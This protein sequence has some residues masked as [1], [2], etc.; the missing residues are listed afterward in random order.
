MNKKQYLE[1]LDKLYAKYEKKVLEAQEAYVNSNNPFKIG[2]IITDNVGSVRITSYEGVYLP[3][4]ED[5]PV[6]V[7]MGQCLDAYGNE[8][9]KER[10]VQQQNLILKKCYRKGIDTLPIKT[11]MKRIKKAK[12]K[13]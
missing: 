7:W 4:C 12:K 6:A 11:K 3:V 13:K 1:E 2:D 5:L 9:G 8:K 10:V